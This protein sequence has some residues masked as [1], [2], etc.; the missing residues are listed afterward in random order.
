MAHENRVTTIIKKQKDDRVFLLFI[1]LFILIDAIEQFIKFVNLQDKVMGPLS[2]S[3]HDVL[4]VGILTTIW[5]IIFEIKRKKKP[6]SKS[7]G[8]KMRVIAV[9]VFMTGLVPEMVSSIVTDVIVTNG[10][11]INPDFFRLITC[12]N[13]ILIILAGFIGTITE[14]FKYGLDLQDES[15]LFA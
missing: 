3:L 2:R 15:D 10:Q 4:L 7:I 6:F 13:F 1:A 12:D 5:L 11:Y 9:L 8:I 14:I